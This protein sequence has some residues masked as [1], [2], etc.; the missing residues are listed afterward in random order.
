MKLL[1]KI[2]TAVLLGALLLSGCSSAAAGEDTLTVAIPKIGKADCS[3]L[4]QGKEALVID[5]GEAENGD[6]VLSALKSAGVTELNALVIT[7]FD[8]DHV[9]GAAQLL[10]AIPVAQVIEPDYTPENP[11]AE[12]YVSYRQALS[13]TGV[14]VTAVRDTLAL[15]LGTAQ[16]TVTGTGGTEY[17]KNIDNN[18]SLLVSVIHGGNRLLFT[19]DAEKQRIEDLLDAG[20]EACDFVKIPHHG[21]Y[22]SLLPQYL[23]AL[24]PKYA[25]ITCSNKNPAD[26]RTLE[27]LDALGIQTFET[28]NGTVRVTSSSQGLR[29][30]Q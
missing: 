7:H 27:T 22:N 6:A 18:H 24:S 4:R 5:C 12:A 16:I 10:R 19:G 30:T 15:S 8:K 26:E 23:S 13:E 20:V 11:E 29:V 1:P 3:I 14:P 17:T 21:S 28:A 9:G 2:T 25:V